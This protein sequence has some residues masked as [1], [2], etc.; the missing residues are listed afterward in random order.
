MDITELLAFSAKQGASDLHLS[1]GLPPVIPVLRFPDGT[2]MNDSTPLA[3]ALEREHPGQRSVIPD[4][5]GLAYLSDLLEDFGDE[6]L[7]K[8]MFHYRWTYPADI[9]KALQPTTLAECRIAAS[10]GS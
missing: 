10:I 1:A 6:W 7:T 3:Y 9:H 2:L 8:A 4:D 5:P